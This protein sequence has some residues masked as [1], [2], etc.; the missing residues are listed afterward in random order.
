MQVA[1]LHYS[2][3]VL[4][5][6]LLTIDSALESMDFIRRTRAPRTKSDIEIDYLGK[7]LYVIFTSPVAL[8]VQA[9]FGGMQDA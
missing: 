5:V 9:L 7:I 3:G 4:T 6:R 1:I 2:T 8:Y